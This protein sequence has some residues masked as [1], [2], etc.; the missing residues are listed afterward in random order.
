M[1]YIGTHEYKNHLVLSEKHHISTLP[2]EPC[3]CFTLLTA[4]VAYSQVN[5]SMDHFTFKP[6]K[7]LSKRIMAKNVLDSV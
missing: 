4:L 3:I 6:L 5:L 7:Q 1:F 2:S